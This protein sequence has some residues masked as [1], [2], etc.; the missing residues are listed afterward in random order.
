M[1]YIYREGSNVFT[2][3]FVEKSLFIIFLKYFF[4][5]LQLRKVKTTFELN[6]KNIL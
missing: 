2:I 3:F 5:I 6:Y 4:E 1:N